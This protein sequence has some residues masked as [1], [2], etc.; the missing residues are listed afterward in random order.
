[1]ICNVDNLETDATQ[2]CLNKI[3][4]KNPTNE[5]KFK[6]PPKYRGLV[7]TTLVLPTDLVCNHC[8]FQ[9]DFN[10]CL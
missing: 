7:N 9:V 6:I 3:I 10:K 5:S 2:E 8:V 1:M 4:L